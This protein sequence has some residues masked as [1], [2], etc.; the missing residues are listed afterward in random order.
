MCKWWILPGVLLRWMWMGLCR[1]S[2]LHLFYG[3]YSFCEKFGVPRWKTAG[4]ERFLHLWNKARSQRHPPSLLPCYAQGQQHL[5]G[6]Q[7]KHTQTLPAP[8]ALTV[9]L[10]C[11]VCSL[12]ANLWLRLYSWTIHVPDPLSLVSFPCAASRE[13]TL[14]TKPKVLIKQ[15]AFISSFEKK[16]WKCWSVINSVTKTSN[17]FFV[18]YLF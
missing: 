17:N 3:W 16:N 18:C 14:K 15:I 1:S 5:S 10:I 8:W 7:M 2:R 13:E 6:T 9:L 12:I 11:S 4:L